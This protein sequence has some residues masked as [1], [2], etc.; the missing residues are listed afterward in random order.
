MRKEERKRKLKTTEKVSKYK[1]PITLRLNNGFKIPAKSIYT[2]YSRLF[3]IKD[4]DIDKIRVSD[5]KLYNKKNDSCKYYVFYEDY[6][7]YI[8]L[9]I[10]LLNVPGYY[11]IFNDDGKTMNFKLDDDSLTKIIDVFEHI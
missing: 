11:N 4:I 3:N 2:E 10:T 8:P 5:K 7:E 9:K 1:K 6:N